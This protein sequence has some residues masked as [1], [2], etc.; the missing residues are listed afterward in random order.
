MSK[1]T[2]AHVDLR[3]LVEFQTRVNANV[4]E[5]VEYHEALRNK[6]QQL[7]EDGWDDDNQ[8]AFQQ[9]LDGLK[10]QINSIVEKY[11]HLNVLIDHKKEV[12][13]TYFSDMSNWSSSR[14]QINNA[15]KEVVAKHQAIETHHKSL[16][17]EIFGEAVEDDAEVDE[18]HAVN[19]VSRA[20]QNHGAAEGTT[21]SKGVKKFYNWLMK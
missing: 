13:D 2:S 19:Q 6:Y 21:D 10:V 12:I 15:A 14:R 4:R 11:M 1:E 16:I 5:L 17:T 7:Q 8:T 20:A 9:I 18:I 3:E